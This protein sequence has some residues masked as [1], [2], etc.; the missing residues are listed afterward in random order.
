MESTIKI[1]WFLEDT[2]AFKEYFMRLPGLSIDFF[3]SSRVGVATD[4]ANPLF[5]THRFY[6]GTSGL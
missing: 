3:L 6:S 2:L 1:N 5:L 4:S